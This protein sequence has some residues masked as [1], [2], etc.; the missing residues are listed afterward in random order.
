MKKRF[1]FLA[2]LL[3]VILAL[4]GTVL[5]QPTMTTQVAG[6]D[7]YGN[8]T[9]DL[10]TQA[11]LDAGF[12][13]GDLIQ[14]EIAGTVFQAPFVTAYSDVDVGSLLVRGPGGVGTAN[15]MLAINMGN[16]AD[17]YGVQEGD[18]VALTLAEKGTYLGEWLIRQLQ[19][20][21]ER[22]DYPSDEVFANFREV[23]TGQMGKG[24]YYRSS[25]PVNNE[26]GRAAYADALMKAAGIKTVINLADGPEELASYFAQPDFN[27]PYYKE[28]YDQGRVILLN[29]GVDFRSADF[30]AKL[31][32][33][34]EFL[35]AHEGPY[36]IHCTEGKDRAGFV[37][38]L[39]EA[40]VGSSVEEIK[41]DYMCSFTNYYGV[42]YGSEQY[43]KIAESNVLA[44]LRDIAG[45]PAGASLEGVD[46][47]AAAEAYLAGIGLSPEQIELLKAKLMA[48]AK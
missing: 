35:M 11:L 4:G 32:E 37:S 45:L 38:A 40:L 5:A 41:D 15:V 22:A 36:L 33:G 9:L 25:S 29:M 44:S 34:L 20:T 27:S 18:A 2:L 6:V 46:L 7:K 10:L 3:V 39:L 21:N 24:I 14:V 1:S 47:S 19:R 23:T 26:L 16:F 17:T 13:F 42:E 8:L 48:D 30:Q 43:E 28:L 12:E 31:K